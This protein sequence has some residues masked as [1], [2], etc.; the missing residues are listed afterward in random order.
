[1]LGLGEAVTSVSKTYCWVDVEISGKRAS[2]N[3]R[4]HLKQTFQQSFRKLK[5]DDPI[6]P[7]LTALLQTC[8]GPIQRKNRTN[9]FREWIRQHWQSDCAVLG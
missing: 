7:A 9:L 8:T 1:M 4:N 6:L 2:Q 3:H 5:L